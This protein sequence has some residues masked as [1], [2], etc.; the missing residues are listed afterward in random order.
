MPKICLPVCLP[1][2]KVP[3]KNVGSDWMLPR[4]CVFVL[5]NFLAKCLSEKCPPFSNELQEQRFFPCLSQW[6]GGHTCVAR[7]PS[8]RITEAGGECPG[9][10][11]PGVTVGPSFCGLLTDATYP[12]PPETMHSD[13]KPLYWNSSIQLP[14]F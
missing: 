13:P 10:K 12:W 2:T 14:V 9:Q 11:K 4:F 8:F 5:H 6:Q 1:L 3:H 7:R